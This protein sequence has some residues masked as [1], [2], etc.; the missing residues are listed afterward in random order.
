MKRALF[1]VIVIVAG[2]FTWASSYT[3]HC[4]TVYVDYGITDN[5]A[6]VSKCVNIGAPTNALTVLQKA[7]VQIEGTAKYGNK[8]VC[9]VTGLPGLEPLG[10]K[11]HE[12]YIETC[13]TMPAEFAY[14]AVLIKRHVTIPIF[15]TSSK[16]G[17][18]QTGIS[19]VVLKPGDSVGLVFADNGHV[20]FP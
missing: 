11:G 20:R 6:K 18:A 2:F 10:I 15:D 13:Q 16:W 1:I 9:R 4:A 8:V 14:W 5:H 19:D 17:W 7:H 12:Q 3:T